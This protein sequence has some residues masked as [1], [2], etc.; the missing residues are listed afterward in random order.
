MQSD[1]ETHKGLEDVGGKGRGEGA[2]GDGNAIGWERKW[3]RLSDRN[4][5]GKAEGRGAV[6]LRVC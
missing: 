5:Q 6:E 2:W 1:L 4:N 3:I